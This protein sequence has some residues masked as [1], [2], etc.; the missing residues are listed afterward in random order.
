MN[1][2]FLKSFLV[3]GGLFLA[4]TSSHPAQGQY[5]Y[6]NCLSG[7]WCSKS[8]KAATIIDLGMGAIESSIDIYQ[9]EKMFKKQMQQM[10][11][12]AEQNRFL[13]NLPQKQQEFQNIQKVSPFFDD[14]ISNQPSVKSPS[15]PPP[16]VGPLR[17]GNGE[18]R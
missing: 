6:G 10:Q 14:V 5:Y 17:R 4:L 16:R 18:Q 12:Q 1:S 8:Y 15:S 11:E 13:M 9:R 3:A 7:P 2:Y